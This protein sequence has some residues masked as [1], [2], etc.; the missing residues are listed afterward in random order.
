VSGLEAAPLTP[1]GFAPF[2]QVLETEGSRGHP[3][4]DG[5]GLRHDGL[6]LLEFL[7]GTAPVVALYEM[8]PSALP[9]PVTNFERHRLSSQL[10]V[11][12]TLDRFL[13]V[14]A[15]EGA[16][17]SP[18]GG[19]ARAFLGRRGQAINYAPGVWHAPM[20]ALDAGGTL[21]MVMG[22]AAEAATDCE[23]HRLPT[24]ILVRSRAG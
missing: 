24:P 9:F 22:R 14:V 4:N 7:D 5:R 2:G 3:V 18:D 21:A 13:V 10:F 15:P 16:G 20:V 17:G 6:G 19:R 8:G 1:A 23:V 12:M 11:P